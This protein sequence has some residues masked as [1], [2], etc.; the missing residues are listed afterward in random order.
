MIEFTQVSSRSWV[1]PML[2]NGLIA[3]T[4]S[5]SHLNPVTFDFSKDK[6]E[7]KFTNIW[8]LATDE[9]GGSSVIKLQILGELS[10]DEIDF[11][12][13]YIVVDND[14][15]RIYLAAKWIPLEGQTFW[16]LDSNFNVTGMVYDGT[17]AGKLH[18]NRGN[19]FF[20]KADAEK[21]SIKVRRLLEQNVL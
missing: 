7:V 8:N 11:N 16:Y 4:L 20:R 12:R 18:L 2:H 9:P 15:K 1:Y 14:G 5:K 21:A 3:N 19:F 13:N 6:P 17:M 10:E